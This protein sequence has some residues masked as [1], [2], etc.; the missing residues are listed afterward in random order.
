MSSD[1][2]LQIM[3]VC[4]YWDSRAHGRRGGYCA[5]IDRAHLITGDCVDC[6]PV[7]LLVF[8]L[9]VVCLFL[10]VARHLNEQARP[11]CT[12]PCEVADAKYATHSKQEVERAMVGNKIGALK[13]RAWVQYLR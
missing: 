10:C 12:K 1:N 4:I 8:L 11:Q 2:T 5:D 9:Y 3:P 6:F 13:Q 7:Q